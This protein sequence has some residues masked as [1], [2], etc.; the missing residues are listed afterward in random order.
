[1]VR[2]V[3]IVQVQVEYESIIMI[4]LACIR[5]VPVE[6]VDSTRDGYTDDTT[7]DLSIERSNEKLHTRISENVCVDCGTRHL[8]RASTARRCGSQA[9][10]TGTPWHS[11]HRLRMPRCDAPSWQESRGR[12]QAA[13]PPPP[14]SPQSLG[15]WTATGSLTAHLPVCCCP[16]SR[17][18]GGGAQGRAPA[19]RDRVRQRLSPAATDQPLVPHLAEVDRS[20]RSSGETVPGAETHN[21]PGSGRSA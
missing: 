8:I 17:P 14:P 13:A 1:M 19:G 20:G 21:R 11:H 18:C 5:S 7:L 3:Y 16:W 12:P 4:G 10:T 15:V 9:K 6:C 2:V